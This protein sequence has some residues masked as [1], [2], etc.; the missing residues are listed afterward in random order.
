MVEIVGV[1]AISLLVYFVMP[2]DGDLGEVLAGSIIVVGTVALVPLSLRR[3]RQ[4]LVSD[5][6]LLVAAQ[7]LFSIISLLIVSF[8][9]VYYVLGTDHQ[10]QISGVN[11]KIDSLYFTVTIT[12]TVGFGDITATGQGAR[13]VVAGHMIINFVLLAVAVRVLSWA[14]Q[15]R[16]DLG[17]VRSREH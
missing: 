2:L 13:V 15:Q 14:L 1:S 3:A 7:S 11:T 9:S 6:P 4:V 5:Q 12:S 16:R 17:G 10:G 8:A